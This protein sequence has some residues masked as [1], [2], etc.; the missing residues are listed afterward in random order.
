MFQTCCPA[1]CYSWRGNCT[2]QIFYPLWRWFLF[3]CAVFPNQVLCLKNKKKP[4]EFSISSSLSPYRTA[5]LRKWVLLFSSN[6]NIYLHS[7]KRGWIFWLTGFLFLFY[8]E[9]DMGTVKLCIFTDK[10]FTQCSRVTLVKSRAKPFCVQ[11]T[12]QANTGVSGFSSRTA[13]RQQHKPL[14]AFWLLSLH[15]QLQPH[16]PGRQRVINL[17]ASPKW[18]NF[19]R[20][21]S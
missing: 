20:E 15:D 8:K 3:H 7:F 13:H 12:C 17:R 11:L 16:Q 10:K 18:Q 5:Y 9:K 21:I 4:P 1:A 2:S 14:D 19:L 6:I